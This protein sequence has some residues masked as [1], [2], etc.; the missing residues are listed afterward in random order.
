MPTESTSIQAIQLV[1]RVFEH[2][3]GNLGVLRFNVEELTPTNGTDT[4]ESKKWKVV[5]SFYETLGSSSPSKYTADVDLTT[6]T[7]S[8]K[9]ISRPDD[10]QP[11]KL[12]GSYVIKKS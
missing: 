1:R 8:F 4:Q 11:E 12:E 10:N 3:N 2:I 9:K 6:N 7:L 5:F